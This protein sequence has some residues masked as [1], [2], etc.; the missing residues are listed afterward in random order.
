MTQLNTP[1]P[2][3]A[4]LTGFLRSRGFDAAQED[5]A[6]ALVLKLFSSD[7]LRLMLQQIEADSSDSDDQSES[8]E[9]FC[10]E[11]EQYAATIDRVIAFLQGRD[12]TLAHRI[13]SRT[14]LPEGPRF[15]AVE[16][17]MAGDND[18]SDDP[19]GW[20]FGALGIQD[21]ARHL[22]TLYLSDLA[23]VVKAAIDPQFEFVRYAESLAASQPTF[24]PLADALAAPMTLVDKTLKELT[25]AAIERH[26]PDMVLVS[27]PFPGSVYAA[28][29]IGQCIKA[30]YPEVPVLLGGGFVNTELRELSDPRVFDYFDFVTL[31][32]GERPLLALFEYLSGERS[33]D[34]LVRTFLRTESTDD[35]PGTVLYVNH[36]EPDNVGRPADRS[37]SVDA[38]YAEPH[39]SA[40]VRRSLE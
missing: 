5:L 30:V 28:F 17:H 3:T 31:D 10:D 8:V 12:S 38:G 22:A 20:A 34:Q 7:G 33:L 32:D 6:L 19:L 39:A 14:F 9:H 29:R 37:V 2:S 1:Y 16:E 36:V 26:R 11:F 35:A 27:V 23:D 13:N 18:D 4:Y 21:R 15:D 24:D 25:L 40:L